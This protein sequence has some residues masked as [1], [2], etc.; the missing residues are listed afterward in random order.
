MV[1][2]TQVVAS[3][4]RMW[5]LHKLIVWCTLDRTHVL[6]RVCKEYKLSIW[7]HRMSYILAQITRYA[8]KFTSLAKLATIFVRAPIKCVVWVHWKYKEEAEKYSQAQYIPRVMNRE[9][10]VVNCD[11]NFQLERG[12]AS[13]INTETN[14]T[15]S[16]RHCLREVKLIKNW[17]ISCGVLLANI[18]STLI[19]EH[20][21]CVICA[22]QN[23][24]SSN[25][26]VYT[27]CLQTV[28]WTIFE[29]CGQLGR[30]KYFC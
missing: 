4:I 16:L 1:L 14:I 26:P 24:S 23:G 22:V 6:A 25:L 3:H 10:I 30:I 5:V 18:K 19:M 29:R 21:Y 27:S 11:S 17:R 9:R 13:A 20:G 2:R 15:N 12:I 8:C 28:P 7:N